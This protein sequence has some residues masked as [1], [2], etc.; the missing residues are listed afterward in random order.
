MLIHET[1]HMFERTIGEMLLV[2]TRT[3]P[4]MTKEEQ[5]IL[6]QFKQDIPEYFLD[7]QEKGLSERLIEVRHRLEEIDKKLSDVM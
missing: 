6:A 7:Q 1:I 3:P 2:H 5:T 4:S